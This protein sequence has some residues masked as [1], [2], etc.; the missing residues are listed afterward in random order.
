M[1]RIERENEERSE[2]VVE[3]SGRESLTR[4]SVLTHSGLGVC[5]LSFQVYVMN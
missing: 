1:I 5:V 3:V 4:R 2:Q